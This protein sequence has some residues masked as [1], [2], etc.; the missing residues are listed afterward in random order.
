PKS[1]K[2]KNVAFAIPFLSAGAAFTAQACK[3]G[4]TVPKPNPYNIPAIINT[5]KLGNHA[6]SNMAAKTKMTPGGIT[7]KSPFVSYSLP[8]NVLV[9]INA[10]AYATKYI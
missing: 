1:K 8:A 4:W 6:N 10:K 7:Y 2:E 5:V 9:N 3:A